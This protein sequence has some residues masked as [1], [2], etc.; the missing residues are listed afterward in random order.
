M[1]F[2]PIQGTIKWENVVKI[3]TLLVQCYWGRKDGET[4][5]K[6]RTVV[7]KN[8]SINTDKDCVQA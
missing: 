3:Q 2:T 7:M 1:Q 8:V 5:P 6:E 4:T